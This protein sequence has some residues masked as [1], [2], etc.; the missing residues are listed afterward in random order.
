MSIRHSY[1]GDTER[2]IHE[3]AKE[4]RLTQLQQKGLF[5]HLLQRDG[6]LESA[7]EHA[8]LQFSNNVHQAKKTKKKLESVKSLRK[9][10]DILKSGCYERDR[11]V[12]FKGREISDRD[13][14]NLIFK[15]AYGCPRPDTPD[16]EE[17]FKTSKTRENEKKHK[18]RR[19]ELFDE[20]TERLEFLDEMNMVSSQHHK[21]DYISIVKQEIAAKVKEL[22][23]LEKS[24]FVNI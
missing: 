17:V 5:L 7:A 12:P 20:I 19:E 1:S 8:H 6:S 18:P 23:V 9:K 16:T 15:L 14:D 3:L 24:K 22:E 10:T 13:K 4:T 21:R 11:Y 2:I